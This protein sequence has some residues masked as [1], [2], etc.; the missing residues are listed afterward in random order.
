MFQEEMRVDNTMRKNAAQCKRKFQLANILGIVSSKGST[1]LRYGATF[2]GF[3]EGFYST[4][5][6]IGWTQR[7]HAIEAAINK[8]KEVWD[9][10]TSVFEY[11][12]DYRT[13][14]NCA[15]TF[16][17]YIVF[18]QQDE[19]FLEV[20]ETEQV[21]ALELDRSTQFEL[22][23]FGKMPRIIFTGKIDLQALIGGNFWI[24]EHKTTGQQPN[25]ISTRLHRNTAVIG[26][27][28]AA[29]RVL[30]RK[31]EGVLVNIAQTAS[32]KSKVTGE[33]GK[34]TID[35]ARSPQLFNDADFEKWKHSFLCTCRDIYNCWDEAYFPAEFDRCY[36]YNK[37]CQYSRICETNRSIPLNPEDSDL[38]LQDIPG[39]IVKRWNVEEEDE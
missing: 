37:L 35:F 4:I 20:I 8:G 34:V 33:Y 19:G 3:M 29:D 17:Q 13:F 38:F 26:Y 7:E 18:N 32:R 30:Q 2:H 14:E 5:K 25:F 36:D 10:E 22:Y 12:D 21:F 28:Y 15:S 11:Y 16:L 23:M 9:K 39:F 27:S 6:E 24:F 1:A 31:P